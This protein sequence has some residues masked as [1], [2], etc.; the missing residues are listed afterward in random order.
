[1][2]VYTEATFGEAVTGQPTRADNTSAVRV[3]TESDETMRN[4][5]KA[6]QVEP[7]MQATDGG[8]GRNQQFE[9]PLSNDRNRLD[10]GTKTVRKTSQMCEQDGRAERRH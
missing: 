4:I 9:W 5:E 10:C 8:R 1:M 7:K 2:I 3:A 6:G